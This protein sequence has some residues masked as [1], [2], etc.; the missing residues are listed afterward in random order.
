MAGT[1]II[2]IG[3]KVTSSTYVTVV[4]QSPRSRLTILLL[5]N[6][7][8]RV[9]SESENLVQS[10]VYQVSVFIFPLEK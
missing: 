6:G 7:A 9:G 8:L 2:A 3:A 5:Y 10:Q 4:I 1:N